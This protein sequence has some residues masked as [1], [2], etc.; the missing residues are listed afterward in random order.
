[1]TMRKRLIQLLIF[2]FVIVVISLV[3]I[4]FNLGPVAHS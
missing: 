2:V 4:W 3:A 1:M